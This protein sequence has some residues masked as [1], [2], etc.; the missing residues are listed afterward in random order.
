MIKKI[1]EAII[2]VIDP[3]LNE[4][5]KWLLKLFLDQ[6]LKLQDIIMTWW[7]GI[8]PMS[9]E[10]GSTVN[11]IQTKTAWIYG[12]VGIISL[13][14]GMYKAGKT[15]SRDDAERVLMGTIR[16]L[17][18]S[19][20]S[21]A[22]TY[23][24]LKFS[25][26]LAYWLYKGISG[27]EATNFKDIINFSSADGHDLILFIILGTVIMF[28]V[29][30][31]QA[32]MGLGTVIAAQILS[33]IL[34]ISAAAS[35]TESGQRAFGKQ[36]GWILA[37]IAFRPAAAII[38]GV[39]VRLSRTGNVADGA[40]AGDMTSIFGSMITGLMILVLAVFAL[41][42]MVKLLVPMATVVG[43]SGGSRFLAGAG[44]MVAAQGA[45]YISTHSSNTSTSNAA[46]QS[47]A[48]LSSSVPTGASMTAAG[49]SGTGA[50][51]AASG[52]TAAG[53]TAG[54]SASGA[55]G[56]AAGS[57]GGPV[58]TGAGAAAGLA[59]GAG[60]ASANT[61][62]TSGTSALGGAATEGS[63]ASSHV[64]GSVTS[65]GIGSEAHPT[66]AVSNNTTTNSGSAAAGPAGSPSGLTHTST[67]ASGGQQGS[68]NH[69]NAFW[70]VQSLAEKTEDELSNVVVAEGAEQ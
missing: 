8:P 60:T 7:F 27:E 30:L 66:G 34:P 2:N 14:F 45:N 38:Y 67:P 59:A 40:N 18:T 31:I 48:E 36:L 50:A 10:Q 57:A 21:V 41:P 26:D 9:I 44:M 6:L 46:T 23:E 1:I 51:T 63:S 5:L 3:M 53:S 64:S 12:V 61:A 69:R 13:C 47:T 49:G 39:G 22:V 25:G 29:S 32:F 42:T 68:G 56:A 16:A 55:A 54:G 19:A 58:G 37:C 35:Q 62:V 28:F 33:A 17:T 24:C 20:I 15:A 70:A 43:G 4:A 52:S 11:V 65:S